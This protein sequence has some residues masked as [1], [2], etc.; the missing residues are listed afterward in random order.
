MGFPVVNNV[1]PT[2]K[3]LFQD[4]SGNRYGDDDE[5]GRHSN[6]QGGYNQGNQGGYNPGGNQGGYN[7]GGYNQ[8]GY[9]QGG[10]NQGGGGYYWLLSSYI[11]R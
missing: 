10:Y 4:L 6:N 2:M 5:G 3:R 9:N 11:V 1:P 8:G 7:Q